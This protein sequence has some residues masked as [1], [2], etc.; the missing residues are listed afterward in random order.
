MWPLFFMHMS[1]SKVRSVMRQ[2]S[3]RKNLPPTLNNRSTAAVLTGTTRWCNAN[4]FNFGRIMQFNFQ[5]CRG[6]PSSY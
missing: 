3:G 4:M 5:N 1:A 6:S 2:R